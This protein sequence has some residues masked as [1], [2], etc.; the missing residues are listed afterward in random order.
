M[1]HIITVKKIT[2]ITIA[3]IVPLTSLLLKAIPK[4]RKIFH[5]SLQLIVI[6]T[7]FQMMFISNKY[8]NF[9]ITTSFIKISAHT[10]M[11][12]AKFSSGDIGSR[13]LVCCF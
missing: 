4:V 12:L 7:I 1:Q 2:V 9:N 11:L 5:Q 13:I 10:L 8:N 3:A 6:C